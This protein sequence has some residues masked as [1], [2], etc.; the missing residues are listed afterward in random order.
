MSRLRRW[1]VVVKIFLTCTRK[2]ATEQLRSSALLLVEV[3]ELLAFLGELLEQRRGLPPVAVLLME[4]RDAIVDRLQA[5]RIGVPH[6]SAAVC[7]EAVAVDVDDVDIHGA[8]R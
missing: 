1:I 4:F 8:Q 6:G 2:T 3:G 7:R 5:D